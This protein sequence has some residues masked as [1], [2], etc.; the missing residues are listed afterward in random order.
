MGYSPVPATSLTLCRYATFL[1]RSLKFNSI[2]QYLNIVRLLHLEWGL[3]NPLK[4]NFS[5]N[6]TLKGIRRH[7]GDHVT[8]KRPIIP[9]V[10]K[11]ILSQLDVSVSFDAAVWAACLIS[12]YG[13]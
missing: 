3:P 4:D 8:R 6:N 5:V 9:G 11:S 2:K 12:F 7:L 1:A 13:L 10:L